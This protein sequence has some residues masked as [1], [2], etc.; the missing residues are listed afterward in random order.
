MM[1]KSG[2]VVVVLLFRNDGAMIDLMSRDAPTVQRLLQ[3][4]LIINSGKNTIG[5]KIMAH[6]GHVD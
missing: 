3:F 5:H 6:S 2:F 4:V 1:V